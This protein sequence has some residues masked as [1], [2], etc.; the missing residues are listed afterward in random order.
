[1]EHRCGERLPVSL[2]A[3]IRKATGEALGATVRNL[4]MGGAFVALP[5]GR[6]V[7]R[8]LVDLE[9]NLPGAAQQSFRWRAYVVH[10]RPEGVGLMFDDQKLAER[11]PFLMAH[12]A[13]RPAIRAVR[14]AV[15]KVERMGL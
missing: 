1:M 3:T 6:A 15:R 9:L 7:L 10:Q 8:G 2:A 11:L 14:S 13:M 5:I 12:R 4:S